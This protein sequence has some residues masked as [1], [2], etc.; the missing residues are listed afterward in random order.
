[1]DGGPDNPLGARAIY[2]FQGKRTRTSA[3]TAPTSRS[4]SARASS[5]GCFRM[6]NEHVMDL[7]RRVKLGTPV[8]VL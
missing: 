1:M 6:V 7:Y 5:N 3:S 4:R 2:L 8:V